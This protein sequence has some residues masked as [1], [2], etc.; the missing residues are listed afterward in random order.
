MAPGAEGSD[1]KVSGKRF[2]MLERIRDHL[3]QQNWTAVALEFVIVVTGVAIGSQI[4]EWNR[5][6]LAEDDYQIARERLIDEARENI[7]AF[8]VSREFFLQKKEA[9]GAAIAVL[10]ACETGDQA[11]LTVTTGLEYLR[12]TNSPLALVAASG[13]ITEQPELI[14]RQA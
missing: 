7:E 1:Q 13:R 3:A 9:L 2:L 5:G 10:E 4:T 11:L 12:Q 8:E 6:R 14:G